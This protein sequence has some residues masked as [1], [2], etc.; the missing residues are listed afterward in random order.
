MEYAAGSLS[1]EERLLARAHFG[2]RRSAAAQVR[3]WESVGAVLMT[4]SPPASLTRSGFDTNFREDHRRSGHPSGRSTS[5]DLVRD[6]SRGDF[7]GLV[8]RSNFW[9]VSEHMSATGSLRILK[10]EPG[11]EANWQARAHAPL[12][13]M[14][15]G[16]FEDSRGR[17]KVGDIAFAEDGVEGPVR[18]WGDQSCICLTLSD[19]LRH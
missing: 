7:R 5:L 17:F 4:A 10:L 1:E 16:G 9:G 14:L 2:L 18:F 3:I 13:L 19:P 12:A 6:I 15:Q 8:W 11:L